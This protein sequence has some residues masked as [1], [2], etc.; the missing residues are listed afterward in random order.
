MKNNKEL[1]I[2]IYF[3][4]MRDANRNDGAAKRSRV[5]PAH[6]CDTSLVQSRDD[7]SAV[8]VEEGAHPAAF[9]KAE[10]KASLHPAVRPP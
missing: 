4:F 9:R 6:R 10:L 7:G 2:N 5:S 8:G 1:M 3:N